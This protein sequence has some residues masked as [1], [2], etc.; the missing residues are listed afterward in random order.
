MVAAGVK[1]DDPDWEIPFTT[2]WKTI[3]PYDHRVKTSWAFV[4]PREYWFRLSVGARVASGVAVAVWVQ[5]KGAQ[6]AEN[7]QSWRGAFGA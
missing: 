6:S 4:Q 5:L 3:V 2:P 7:E 1:D